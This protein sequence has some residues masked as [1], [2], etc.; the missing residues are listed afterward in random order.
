MLANASSGLFSLAIDPST[1]TLI[2]VGGDYQKADL[3]L[4]HI[5]INDR[6]MAKETV[7]LAPSGS[8]PRGFRSAVVHS[9]KYKRPWICVGPNGSDWSS[10]GNSWEPLSDVGFHALSVA[11]D[12]TVWA[13][14]S[15]GRV[16]KLQ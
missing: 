15:E 14:G 11:T 16:A 1:N 10:D 4:G 12:G 2:A 3:A 8:G 5:A 6:P 7:W 9:S 13:S